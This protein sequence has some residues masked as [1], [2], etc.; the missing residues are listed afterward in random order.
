MPT[1]TAGMYLITDPKRAV[2][3]PTKMSPAISVASCKAGYAAD[4]SAA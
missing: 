1:L 3:R 2:P 4:W